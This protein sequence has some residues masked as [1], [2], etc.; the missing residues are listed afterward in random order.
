MPSTAAERLIVNPENL[1]EPHIH[2][3]AAVIWRR[4]NSRQLLIAQ[5][6]KGKHLQ[7]YWEFPG[8]KLESGETRWQALRRELE[9]EVGIQITHG[10]PL[11]RVYYRYPERN[12]LLDVWNVDRY[13]GEASSR[14]QQALRWIELSQIDDYQYPPADLPV[15]EAIKNNATAGTRRLP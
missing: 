9:E 15:I 7:D 12:V 2:V 6:Q 10:E 4:G 8:G 5:R 11:I 3:V 14:E 13:D 1:E